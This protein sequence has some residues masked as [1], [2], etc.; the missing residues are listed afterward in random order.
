LRLADTHPQVFLALPFLAENWRSYVSRAFD[1][2]RSFLHQW[3]VNWRMVPPA[4]FDSRGFSAALL[5][6]HAAVLLLFVRKW[7]RLQPA[8]RSCLGSDRRLLSFCR[9]GGGVLA[10][11]RKGWTDR[12]PKT[13]PA[14]HR[15][16]RV[17]CSALR[18]CS[19]LLLRL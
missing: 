4:V 18:G 3:T 16:W 13:I 19:F 1:F 8:T 10:V 12:G 6:C 11:L 9:P 7:C 17:R 14:A 5:G 2:S 15:K